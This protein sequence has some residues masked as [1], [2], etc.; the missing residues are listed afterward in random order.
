VYDVN[1][2]STLLPLMRRALDDPIDIALDVAPLRFSISVLSN[3]DTTD[4][5]VDIVHIAAGGRSKVR[6]DLNLTWPP[7]VFSLSHIAIPFR[8]DDPLYG[9]G[10]APASVDAVVLGAIAPRG[11]RSVLSLSPNYFLRLRYNPFYRFQEAR[12]RAW[13]SDIGRAG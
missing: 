4:T 5:A 13:L 1:R 6:Q 7:A 9:D 3:R 2:F 11:E 12:L 10:S 8:A